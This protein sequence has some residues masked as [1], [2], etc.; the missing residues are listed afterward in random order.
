MRAPGSRDPF[1]EAA[2][3]ASPA[4]SIALVIAEIAGTLAV[5]ALGRIAFF[6]GRFV[7]SVLLGAMWP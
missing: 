3:F 6:G 1:L 2:I 4:V 7:G 5:S